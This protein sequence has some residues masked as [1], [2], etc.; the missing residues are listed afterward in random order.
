MPLFEV[1][2]IKK[3][4][5]KEIDDGTGIEILLLPPTAVLARDPNS[6]V[7]AAVTRDGGLKD[8]DPNKSEVMVRSFQ[9][10]PLRVT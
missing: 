3:P 7:I 8:F 1:A 2:I 6:A 4:S 9:Q 10:P 5:K